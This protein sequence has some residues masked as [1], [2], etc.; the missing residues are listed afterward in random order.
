MNVPWTPAA[1]VAIG[2]DWLLEATVP[3]SAFG[4]RQRARERA[5][6]R[7]DERA[8]RQALTCVERIAR[9]VTPEALE[10]LCAAFGGAPDPRAVVARAQAGDILGDV[11]FFEIAGFLEALARIAALASD[12]AFAQLEVLAPDDTLRAAIAPAWTPARTF[13]LD[14]ALAVEL[15]AARAESTARTAVFDAARSRIEERVARALGVASL[16]EGEFVLMRDALAGPLPTDVRVVREAPTYV[17]CELAFDEETLAA[18]AARDAANVHV[19]EEEERLRARLSAEVRRA[20]PSLARACEQLGALD[21]FVAR[22]RFA[23]RYGGVVPELSD[24]ASLAFS[25]ARNLPLAEALARHGHGYAPIS[26]ELEGVGVV[27]GPNMGGK[28]AALRT[29]GFVAACAA[30]GLPVPAQ[31]ARVPLVDEIAWVGSAPGVT[32]AAGSNGLLSAFGAEVV[33]L[34]AFF[35]RGST[36]ALVL[37]DEFARTTSPREARALSIALLER[38]AERGACAL[39]A[40]HLSGI[41]ADAGVAHYAVAGLRRTP[42][43]GE[44]PLDLDEALARIAGAMDY[45]LER[46]DETASPRADA[47]ALADVLGLDAM[48]IAQAREA[49]DSCSR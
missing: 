33:A 28:T 9:A 35:E 11:D 32:E 34:R 43:R 29:C 20:A 19:A 40:T 7:G 49:L 14:D 45:R 39:A 2:A 10:A 23:Q 44:T 8:A 41:A 26:L 30:L 17:L 12:P 4:R 3:A 48:L 16:R 6:R 21:C 27:T 15:A 36:R 47:L 24:G 38:L 1:G 42:R 18:L 13:Y 31:R 5:F 37:V 46:V 22:A 25:E